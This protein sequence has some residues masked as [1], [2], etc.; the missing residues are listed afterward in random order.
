MLSQKI[1]IDYLQQHK[2]DFF[3]RYKIDK[4]GLFGSFATNN[5]TNNSD[6]DIVYHTSSKGLTFTQTLQLENEY[7][8]QKT[9]PKQL[10]NNH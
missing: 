6:I 9:I 1:I 3:D 7:L 4:I 10:S 5:D 8:R 2:I